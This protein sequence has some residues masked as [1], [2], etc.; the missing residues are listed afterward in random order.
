MEIGFGTDDVNLAIIFAIG[1]AFK[2]NIELFVP[3]R[4]PLIITYPSLCTVS[5]LSLAVE[6]ADAAGKF[7]WYLLLKSDSLELDSIQYRSTTLEKRL[8]NMMDA[9]PFVYNALVLDETRATLTSND[10]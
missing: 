8:L 10:I 2:I 7:N 5:T 9:S 6:A 4:S 3:N 1:R